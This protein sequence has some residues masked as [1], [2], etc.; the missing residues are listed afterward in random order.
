MKK[1]WKAKSNQV[2][3]CFSDGLSKTSM[4]L[5]QGNTAV[6]VNKLVIDNFDLLE[7]HPTGLFYLDHLSISI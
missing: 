2:R 6:E 7:E 5:G 3:F 1:R 4:Y